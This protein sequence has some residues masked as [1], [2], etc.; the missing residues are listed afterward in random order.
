MKQITKTL[1]ICLIASWGSLM[2]QTS[3]DAISITGGGSM[4]KKT[5]IPKLTKVGVAQATVIFKTVTTKEFYKNER[6]PLGGRKHDGGSMAMRATAFLE[7]SDGDMTETD[8]REIA[9]YYY[10]ALNKSFQ[11]NGISTIDWAKI[12]AT[13]FYQSAESEQEKPTE[14]NQRGHAYVAVNANNGK[15]LANYSPFAK[16]N[17]GFAMGKLKKA[18]NFSKDIEAPE[19][20]VHAVLDFADIQLDG[21]V[22][23]KKS[24]Q[25]MSLSLGFK[26]VK[27]TKSYT[28]TAN[29]LPSVSVAGGASWDGRPEGGRLY[30]FNDKMQGD[31][32]GFSENIPS[33]VPYTTEVTQDPNRKALKSANIFAKDFN[34]E[35][36]VMVT[37]RA[38]YKAAAKKAL[39]NSAALIAKK[40]VSA[41]G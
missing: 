10:T 4:G 33:N 41:K 23:T 14:A 32:M 19:V 1:I 27:T 7:F 18:A 2:A 16:M 22:K 3:E 21:D 34:Y 36:V 8:Y 28:T 31:F 15:T 26:I 39:Q 30:F 6:G 29:A 40:I 5:I 20:F 25:D 9:D 24:T 38:K 17:M 13:E 35:P 11:D 12:T 37:T